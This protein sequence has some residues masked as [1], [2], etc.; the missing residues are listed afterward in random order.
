M[1]YTVQKA[2]CNR[3]VRQGSGAEEAEVSGGVIEG[4][5]GAGL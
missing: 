1:T 4:E 2:P 3:T 5:H